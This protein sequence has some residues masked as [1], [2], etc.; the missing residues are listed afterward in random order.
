L[1]RLVIGGKSESRQD[2]RSL[3]GMKSKEQEEFDE[4]RITDLTSWLVTGAKV[5]KVGGGVGGRM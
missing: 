2:F 5:V 1:I 4:V 3:V